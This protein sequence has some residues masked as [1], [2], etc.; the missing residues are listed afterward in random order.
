MLNVSTA[1]T[2]TADKFATLHRLDCVN[3]QLI[4][5]TE[6]NAENYEWEHTHALLKLL[7]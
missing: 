5:H 1:A 7:N 4:I 6:K 2:P 3:T